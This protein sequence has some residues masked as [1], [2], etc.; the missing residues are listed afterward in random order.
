MHLAAVIPAMVPTQRL[1]QG[2]GG[3]ELCALPAAVRSTGIFFFGG[4]SQL[5]RPMTLVIAC[6]LFRFF[7]CVLACACVWVSVSL[8]PHF[9]PEDVFC[10]FSFVFFFFVPRNS[11]DL[12]LCVGG[13]CGRNEENQGFFFSLARRRSASHDDCGSDFTTIKWSKDMAHQ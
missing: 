12:I 5:K 1:I 2:S 3:S 6:A 4:G 11:V 13:L 10:F 7:F 8:C 9:V